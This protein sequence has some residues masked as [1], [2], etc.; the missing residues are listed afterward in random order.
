[1]IGTKITLSGKEF[2]IEDSLDIERKRKYL[3]SDAT[4]KFS[5]VGFTEVIQNGR[6]D[7]PVTASSAVPSLQ[8][9]GWLNSM[10]TVL[11]A[12]TNG[13]DFTNL[14]GISLPKVLA[15]KVVEFGEKK[16]YGEAKMKLL[17]SMGDGK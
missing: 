9:P 7:A 16:G 10:E 8:D 4:G 14:K 15:D 6:K 17:K 5:L 2:T 1:M 12:F 3:V 11:D 13:G